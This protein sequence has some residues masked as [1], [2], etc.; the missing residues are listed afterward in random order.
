MYRA[1]VGVVLGVAFLLTALARAQ[2]G[3]EGPGEAPAPPPEPA[4]V[5]HRAQV[6]DVQEVT[7]NLEGLLC[8]Y[9]SAGLFGDAGEAVPEFRVRHGA[10]DLTVP[11]E[12]VRNVELQA[13]GEGKD[14]RVAV[15]LVYREEG[16]VLEGTMEARVELR[17]SNAYGGYRIALKDV[18]RISFD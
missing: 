1:R 4:P 10:A 9:G 11:F 17:G 7:H 2:G 12:R 16:Q 13:Q 5:R 18:R 8:H 3:G 15:V 6:L 14:R